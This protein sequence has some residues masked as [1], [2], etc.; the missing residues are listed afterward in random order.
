MVVVQALLSD[1]GLGLADADR[2]SIGRAPAAP[3][4]K[5]RPR[6]P[7]GRSRPPGETS[8]MTRKIAPISVCE[9]R[10]DEADLLRVVVEDDEEERA[11]PGALE[12]VEPADDGDHEHVDR[13]AEVDRRRVDVAVPPDEEDAAD[14]RDERREAERDRPVQ[15]D[16]VAERGH[17]DRVVADALQRQAERRPDDVAQQRVDGERHAERDVVEPVL[18]GVD[19]ADQAAASGCR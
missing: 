9:A 12:P 18:V 1:S 3:E 2:S 16:V 19:A 13:R 15:H 17:P 4:S 8:T 10:P 14:R 11:D 5:S 7:R 6:S